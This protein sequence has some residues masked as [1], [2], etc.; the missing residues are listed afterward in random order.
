MSRLHRHHRTLRVLLLFG[1]V[2]LASAERR[3][4]DLDFDTTA[5]TRIENNDKADGDEIINRLVF[6]DDAKEPVAP[7]VTNVCLTVAIP[8][9]SD[10]RSLIVVRLSESRAPPFAIAFNA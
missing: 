5:G 9:D 1:L 7:T 4:A 10:A 6:V 3:L 8:L 2:F